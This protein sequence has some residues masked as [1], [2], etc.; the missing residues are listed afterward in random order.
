[1][2]SSSRIEKTIESALRKKLQ[3]YSPEPSHMPFHT[4][5]LGRDRMAL[6][7]F[8]HSLCTNF[9]TAIFEKV[10]K[11]IADG[12]FD[13]V[14]PQYKV[15]GELSSGAQEAI[16][17]IMNGLSEGSRNP[18]HLDEIEQ[19]RASSRMGQEVKK[20]LR[21]VDIYLS[22]NRTKFLIDLKTAKPNISG[23]EKHK[24]DMLEWAAA[25][26][27]KDPSSN[28]RTIIAIPYNPYE[29]KPY[30]RWTMRGMLEIENQ[31]QLMVGD[32]FWNF[33]AGGQDVYTELLD[34]FE[35]V[36]CRM[37]EEID[38][39]FKMLE[40]DDTRHKRDPH[41]HQ[42]NLKHIDSSN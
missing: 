17:K 8:I 36:G 19:I 14:E 41:V 26:L 33:L 23:F 35:S 12:S 3:N 27:Y 20:K 24:Q 28:V 10:A 22:D 15:S 13:H 18:N 7:S 9:G 4:R 6:Y 11:E 30:N 42:P 1:M 2:L 16:T 39:Y 38:D 21:S 40:E 37:R 31:S 34:C 5:L 29:P 25:I 32:E